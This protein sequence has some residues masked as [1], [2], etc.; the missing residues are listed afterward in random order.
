[1]TIPAPQTAFDKDIRSEFKNLPALQ[2][3]L[4]KAG[5]QF[6]D[7]CSNLFVLSGTG[8]YQ[9]HPCTGVLAIS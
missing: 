8:L 2:D 3:E 4:R 6:F 5:L 7:L 1:M 9:N